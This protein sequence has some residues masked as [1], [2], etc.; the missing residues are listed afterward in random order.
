[1]KTGLTLTQMAHEIERQAA[2][3]KDY[4][5]D[6]RRMQMSPDAKALVVAG[7]GQFGMTSHSRQQLATRL[8]I[9]RPFFERL[10]DKHP[11]ILSDT[12]NK[13]FQREPARTMVRVLDNNVRGLV[14]DSYRPLDNYDLADAAL[15]ALM[16]IG[17]VVESCNITETRMYIK[18]T[19]P[20][21]RRELPIPEGLVMGQGHTFFTRALTGAIS[22]SNSE[23]GAGGLIVN[24]GSK[25]EQCTNLAT[26]VSGFKAV[27]LG[28]AKGTDD[29]VSEFMTAGTKRLEDAAIW[30]KL[31]D[32]I[33][34][35]C[36]GRVMDKL[37]A[38]MLKARADVITGNPADVIEVFGKKNN[39]TE[40]ERG[41]LLR[42]FTNSGEATRYGL[43]WAVTRLAG[44]AED[45]D[46]ASE[47]ERLGGRVIELPRSDWQ[48]LLKAA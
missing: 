48:Q 10:A 5:A 38:E 9:P 19:I 33:K 42:H 12:V 21:L 2:Q 24:P 8:E 25:E 36:D 18:A 44:E 1:M 27:H 26:F 30:A 11:D 22:I 29:E 28:K 39:L 32:Y 3:K 35:I 7:T 31:R 43:Q 14:S 45:Y 15:P 37:V 46:R 4:L 47:L 23:V 6:T 40:D 16:D 41:G 20:S 17:A 13:L 34:A